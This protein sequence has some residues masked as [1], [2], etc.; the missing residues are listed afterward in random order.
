MK[1]QLAALILTL[2]VAATAAVFAIWPVVAHAPWEGQG[3]TSTEAM[4]CEGALTF[5]DAVIAAG[6]YSPGYSSSLGS[7]PVQGNPSGLP[8]YAAELS[9]AEREINSYC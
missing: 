7:G 4:R 8:D 9:K 2:A 6:Q 3:T 5:R 1:L